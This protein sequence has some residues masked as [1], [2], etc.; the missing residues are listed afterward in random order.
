MKI[1]QTVY[2]IGIHVSMPCGAIENILAA[3]APQT[4]LWPEDTTYPPDIAALLTGRGAR[5][6]PADA[7]VE[8]ITDGARLWL[9]SASERR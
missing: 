3:T 4:I 2:G 6:V 8:V 7:V 1:M 9:P 5:R